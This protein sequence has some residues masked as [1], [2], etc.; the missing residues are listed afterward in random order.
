MLIFS[1]IISAG[2]VL[3]I[4]WS[5]LEV[6][7]KQTDEIVANI[8]ELFQEDLVEHDVFKDLKSEKYFKNNTFL[9]SDY[10]QDLG[11]YEIT[12][13]KNEDTIYVFRRG[14]KKII[15]KSD[16]IIHFCIYG[17]QFEDGIE[18][19]I[20]AEENDCYIDFGDNFGVRETS[21]EKILQIAMALAHMR[22][23]DTLMEMALENRSYD[24]KLRENPELL[25]GF[26]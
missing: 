12:F 19:K 26:F 25:K 23:H 20:H 6:I 5:D 3:F 14:G 22:K 10:A 7:V 16:G 18:V 8:I 2:L 4:F 1:L 21:K 13:P 11:Y 9:L 17:D 15:V 24:E